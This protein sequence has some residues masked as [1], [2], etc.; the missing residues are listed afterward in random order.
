MTFSSAIQ[1]HEKETK[2][3]KKTGKPSENHK[4]STTKFLAFCLAKYFANFSLI[5]N[6]TDFKRKREFEGIYRK[7][8]IY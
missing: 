7:S 5:E 2:V 3:D 6:D 4:R 1:L 8:L